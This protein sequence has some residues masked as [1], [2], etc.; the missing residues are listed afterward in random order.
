MITFEYKYQLDKGS[1]KHRCPA[2]G[3]SRFVR[4]I[5]TTTGQY[6]PEEFGRCDR[7]V[8]CGYF[9]KPEKRTGIENN[10]FDPSKRTFY[11]KP[12]TTKPTVKQSAI[13]WDVVTQSLTGQGNNRFIAYLTALFG[14]SITLDLI[15]RY[16]IGS[17]SSRWRGATVFWFIDQDG[18]ARSGQVKLFDHTGH[19]VKALK[20]DGQRK[21]CTTWIHAVIEQAYKSKGKTFPSWL[22]DILSHEGPHVTCLFGE[23][24]LNLEPAK[25][26]AIVEAPATAIVASAYLPAFT[27]LA[28]G[29]LSYLTVERCKA[30]KSR[31]V[32]LFPDLSK[33][34]KAFD[35]WSRKAKELSPMAKVYVSNYLEQHATAGERLQGLDLRDYL[36]RFD[37]REFI[38]APTIEDTP[39]TILIAERPIQAIS[40]ICIVEL[41]KRFKGFQLASFLLDEGKVCD[42]LFD[43]TG[44]LVTT[45]NEIA[46]IDSIAK[47]FNKSFA[48]YLI[49]NEGGFIH[50]YY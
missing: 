10:T 14:E 20:P 24:L 23:H 29:S 41:G 50:W 36:T 13:P 9:L 39:L 48:Q 35:L 1:R 6:L 44:E 3:K 17:S 38:P 16:H 49:S 32:Y 33:D 22:T 30:L 34:G 43:A 31:D 7:E 2:C 8:N 46:L 12:I 42:I 21:S 28:A 19:T 4:F 27:W 40:L 15:S 25:P 37:Y 47:T 45:D 26:I 18:A 5:H 11:F